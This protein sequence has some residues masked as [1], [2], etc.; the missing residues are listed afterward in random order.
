M[1]AAAVVYDYFDGKVEMVP[2][3]YN[4]EPR[5]SECVGRNVFIVDFSFKRSVLERLVEVADVVTMLDHHKTAFEELALNFVPYEGGYDMGGIRM[6]I[7]M[8][9]ARS[10]AG[11]TWDYF[12]PNKDRPLLID[13]VEDRDLW[14][15]R[16]QGSKS[17]HL[18]T[19]VYPFVIDRWVT[20][21]NEDK[22]VAQMAS[23]GRYLE[24]FSRNML[25]NSMNATKHVVE[26]DGVKTLGCN[27]PPVFASEAGNLLAEETGTFGVVWYVNPRGDV[28]VSLRSIGGF[29]VSA[30]A[31]KFGGGGHHNAAGFNIK[32]EDASNG[33]LVIT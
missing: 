3:S 18:A 20:L 30:I 32:K 1:A 23:N 31:K 27:L 5:F 25:L 19:Q 11:I 28:N 14:R 24:E 15:F 21:L 17:F 13:L 4:V 12:Y 26:I 6:V 7:H 9:P 16:L 22:T 8:D 2:S 29:D 33:P 10:G